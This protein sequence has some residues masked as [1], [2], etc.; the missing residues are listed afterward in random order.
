MNKL[1]A[2]QRVAWVL[3]NIPRRVVLTSSFGA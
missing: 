3:E 2:E 1:S